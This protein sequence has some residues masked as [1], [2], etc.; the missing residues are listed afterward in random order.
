MLLLLSISL[1]FDDKRQTLKTSA[2]KGTEQRSTIGWACN[3]DF[4]V[5]FPC[6]DGAFLPLRFRILLPAQCGT[7]LSRRVQIKAETRVL[8]VINNTKATATNAQER[9]GEIKSERER[10]GERQRERQ[11]ERQ[12]ERE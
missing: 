1:P 10:E 12:R 8:C 4:G 2:K 5:S 9:A 11:M 6:T 7:M 3:I